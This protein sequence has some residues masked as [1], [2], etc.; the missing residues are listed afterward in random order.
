MSKK[1]PIEQQN[2]LYLISGISFIVAFIVGVLAGH[3]GAF[4]VFL[5]LGAVFVA[6]GVIGSKS[7]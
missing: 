7:K 1:S 3:G 2:N 6:L 4:I 5:P